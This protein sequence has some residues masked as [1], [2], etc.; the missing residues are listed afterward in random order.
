MDHAVAKLAL[1]ALVEMGA[2]CGWSETPGGVPLGEWP[3]CTEERARQMGDSFPWADA[4]PA[5]YL[6]MLAA[7]G[8]EPKRTGDDTYRWVYTICGRHRAWIREEDL[9]G[10]VAQVDSKAPCPHSVLSESGMA[11][12]KTSFVG[13]EALFLIDGFRT[14]VFPPSLHSDGYYQKRGEILAWWKARKKGQAP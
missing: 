6:K 2:V 3:G 9:P 7:R 10:L 5:D 11:P 12:L 1:V 4:S 13:Q 8:R 14:G